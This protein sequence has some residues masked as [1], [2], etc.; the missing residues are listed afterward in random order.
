MTTNTERY[1]GFLR[2]GYGDDY[3]ALVLSEEGQP[4]AQQVEEAIE[5]YGNFLSVRYW[6]TVASKQV[7]DEKLEE[8]AVRTLL[9]DSEAE[10]LAH[11]SEITGY[12]W[13]DELLVVGGHDLLHELRSHLKE[14][15][16]VEITY[17][18]ELAA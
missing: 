11:Y 18:K 7:P 14:W 4:L 1:R 10:Y 15:C 9:G 16:V 8:S 3:D 13:T 17:S 6:T 12:L 5:S 2:E